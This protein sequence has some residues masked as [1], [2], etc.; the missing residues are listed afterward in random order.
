MVDRTVGEPMDDRV[1]TA[2]PRDASTVCLVRDGAFGLEVLMVRRTPA[3][4]FMGG[5]WVFPG[6]AIDPDDGAVPGLDRWQAA[7]VRE[8][9]EETGI[10]L[11]SSGPEVTAARPTGPDIFENAGAKGRRF[12]AESLHYFARW[13]TPAP[14]PIRFDARFFLAVVPDGFDPVIDGSELV[15]FAWIDPADALVR[16]NDGAWVV[17]F[18]T[19]RT[20]TSFNR[21]RSTDE[22]LRHA[23]RSVPVSPIQPRLAVADHAVKIL[24]PG[25]HGYESAGEGERDP[26]LME[27][28]QSVVAR[29]GEVP[30]DFAPAT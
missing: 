12:S 2:A 19:L 5:A 24:V 11:F 14:L 3:A 25:D 6:G 4:R 27:R 7:A 30:P 20:I 10:W 18:P 21:Y 9:V 22:L 8:L 26:K 23:G 29:G 17:A 16:A 13:I 28:L 15:D 1:M